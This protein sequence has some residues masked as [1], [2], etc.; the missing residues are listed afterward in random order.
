MRPRRAATAGPGRLHLPLMMVLAAAGLAAPA[1][2]QAPRP[3]GISGT[4][5]DASTGQPIPKARVELVHGGAGRVVTDAEGRFFLPC[6]PGSAQIRVVADLYRPRRVK[7]ITV[8]GEGRFAVAVTLESDPRAVIE[9]VVSARADTRT[10]GALLQARKRSGS[11]S[12]AVSNEEIART[13][14]SSASDAVKRLVATTLVDGRYVAVRGLGGR[15][16]T[17]LLN[18]VNLPSPDPDVVSFPIDLLPASLLS[19]LSVAKTHTAEMPA[20]FGGGALMIETNAFPADLEARVKLGTGL[21][22]SSTFRS[23]PTHRGGKLDLLGF[24]DGSRSLPGSLP[25]GV[26]LAPGRP[27]VDAA[28]LEASGEAFGNRWDATRKS[29][30]PSLDLS[31]TVGDTVPIGRSRLGY[32]VSAGFGRK[33]TVRQAE[34]RKVTLAEDGGARV[35][36]ESSTI[37]G[38]E[39]ARLAALVDLGLQIDPHNDLEILSL[40]IH[41]ADKVAEQASGYNETDA[42]DFATTRLQ[43]ITRTLSFTQLRGIHRFPS[44]R[45]LELQWEGDVSLVLRDEPDTR[46]I[47]HNVLSDGRLRLSQGPGSAERRFTNLRD[48]AFGGRVELVLPLTQ[49]RLLLGGA[50]QHS[51]R[52]MDS[53]RFRYEFVGSNP[54]ALYLPP[55]EM[56]SPAH[57]GPDFRIEEKT[58]HSDA[59]DASL[60]VTSAWLSAEILASNP[61]RITPGLRMEHARQRL[62]SGTPYSVVDFAEPGVRRSDTAW[63]PSLNAVWAIRPDMN[64][65]LGYAWTLARPQFRE[66]APFAYFDFTRRRSIS[67]N[68]DLDATRI[69]A[70]DLRWEWF[71][72]GTD[73]VVAASVFY[74]HF[75]R[76]IERVILAAS[77]GDVGYDNAPS[78]WLAGG[79]LELRSSLGVLWRGLREFRFLGNAAVILSRVGFSSGQATLQTSRNRPLQG[80]SLYVVNLGMGWDHPA[81]GTEINVLYNAFG[82]RISE[83]GFD[84][85]PDVYEEPVHRLDLTASQ[86]L[87]KGFR[88][89]LALSNLAYQPI[90]ARQGGVT[91]YRYQPGISGTL[92]VDWSWKSGGRR[93]EETPNKGEDR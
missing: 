57:I 25:R 22:S 3:S 71:P 15:Y 87:G 26:P 16:T 23:M 47:K 13:P 6:G 80:Q 44:A 56:L 46:D 60:L 12:D 55:E 17:T 48:L 4:V 63:V 18:R 83:V 2:A 38:I 74:K 10:E 50:A 8:D 7:G 29:A 59:Y 31:A 21:A 70:T 37:G 19:N 79:E 49:V 35:R 62:D 90:E 53:R 41:D 42:Q 33:E 24:D 61:V 72:K 27:G 9:V 77:S 36:E 88:V 43:F 75:D 54:A 30:M 68:P 64:L 14:D 20:N 45:N 76:P 28:R 69:H 1:L 89:R 65:R 58:I 85:L 92:S 91:V 52:E 82:R 67:G 32:L 34:V 73:G 66:L 86:R 81:T 40:Y 84:R 93:G 51:A 11:V 39:N 5:G 78:A